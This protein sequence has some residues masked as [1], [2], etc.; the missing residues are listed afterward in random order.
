MRLEIQSWHKMEELQLIWT[1]EPNRKLERQL[2]GVIVTMIVAGELQ[3]RF[4]EIA[5]RERLIE[6]KAYLIEKAIREVE[7]ER[8]RVAD[9]KRRLSEARIDQLLQQASAFDQAETIRKYVSAA[10][11]ANSGLT[12]PAADSEL[13]AWSDWAL[14]QADRI[15]PVRSGLFTKIG[16]VETESDE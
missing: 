16:V 6:H 13:Q 5:Q 1:D 3:Y 2:A 12:K 14:A 7:E 11:A 15:D 9:E 4:G 8:Q 10:Q